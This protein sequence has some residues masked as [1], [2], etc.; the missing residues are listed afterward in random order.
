MKDQY[1]AMVASEVIFLVEL[2]WQF[3]RRKKTTLNMLKN[4]LSSV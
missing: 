2:T 4:N 1:Q 3:N